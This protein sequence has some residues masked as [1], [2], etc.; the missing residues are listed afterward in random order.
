V[1]P[2]VQVDHHLIMAA[3]LTSLHPHHQAKAKVRLWAGMVCQ[4]HPLPI[5]EQVGPLAAPASLHG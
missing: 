3:R 1:L 5:W 2:L 4:T